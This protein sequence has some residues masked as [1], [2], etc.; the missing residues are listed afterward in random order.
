VSERTSDFVSTHFEDYVLGSARVFEGRTISAEDIDLHAA[1]TGDYFPHHMDADWCATQPF[2]RR[3]A[4]GTLVLSI[5]VGMT[6]TDVN[7][8]A[9]SYG[10]D[11]IRF[12]RPVFIGDTINV[13]A[14]ISSLREYPKAPTVYG[15]VDEELCVTNQHGAVVLALVHVYLV[16]RT[17][18][19]QPSPRGGTR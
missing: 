8:A 4:H 2:G 3:M 5:A 15:L 11:R 9:M 7:P 14:E 12:V 17:P 1:Q 16:N 10:Y 13:R 6:A 18:M 19:K